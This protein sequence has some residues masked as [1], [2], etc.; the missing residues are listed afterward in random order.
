MKRI[1]EHLKTNKPK[2][3]EQLKEES[4][5]ARF[6]LDSPPPMEKNNCDICRIEFTNYKEVTI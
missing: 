2:T 4:R 3:P 6:T 1:Y 5:Q